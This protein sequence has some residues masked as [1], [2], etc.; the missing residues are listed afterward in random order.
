MHF[1][2]NIESV[3]G[4]ID[5][6]VWTKAYIVNEKILSD[7]EMNLLKKKLTI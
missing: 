2:K 5:S 1:E 4:I 3:Q 6:I 7:L